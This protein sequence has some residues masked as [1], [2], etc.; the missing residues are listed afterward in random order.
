MGFRGTRLGS[1]LVSLDRCGPSL[2]PR[3]WVGTWCPVPGALLFKVRKAAHALLGDHR[4]GWS[5]PRPGT[6]DGLQDVAVVKF[7][8]FKASWCRD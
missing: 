1:S 3:L 7:I 5:S 4:A 6:T 2:C 8:Y